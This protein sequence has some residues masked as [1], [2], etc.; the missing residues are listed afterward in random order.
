MFPYP[1]SWCHSGYIS[2][3][4]LWALSVYFHNVFSS[5]LYANVVLPSLL[6]LGSATG[7]YSLL[8]LWSF[9]HQVLAQLGLLRCG[10]ELRIHH[11]GPQSPSFF[12]RVFIAVCDPSAP[13]RRVLR[14]SK[15]QPLQVSFQIDTAVL[16]FRSLLVVVLVCLV[17]RVTLLRPAGVHGLLQVAAIETAVSKRHLRFL[18][19]F[20]FQEESWS[21]D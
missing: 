12:A 19:A 8:T 7:Q 20:G 9:T 13:F 11:F 14:V 10:H 2:G 4:S 15:R 5:S 18:E 17:P 6:I 3:V 21:I 16:E 1:V